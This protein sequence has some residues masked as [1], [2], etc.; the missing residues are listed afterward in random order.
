MTIFVPSISAVSQLLRV[1]VD[2]LH[3]A[4]GVFDLVNRVLQLP[5]EH[6][7]VGDHH[8]AVEDLYSPSRRADWRAGARATK[9]C[10]SSRCRRSV[11]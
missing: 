1:L 2:R 10:S 5:V 7:P 8:D 9:C 11:E 6:L 4:L 3:H